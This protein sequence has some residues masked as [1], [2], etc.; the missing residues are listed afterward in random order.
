MLNILLTNTKDSVTVACD[1][2]GNRTSHSGSL[3][4][5]FC[6]FLRPIGSTNLAQITRIEEK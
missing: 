5:R 3:T 2:E 1:G 6:R 4:H